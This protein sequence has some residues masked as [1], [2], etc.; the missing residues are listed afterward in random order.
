VLTQIK[1]STAPHGRFYDIKRYKLY[2]SE[3]FNERFRRYVEE[4]GDGGQ[5]YAEEM[6]DDLMK[7]LGLK[8]LSGDD[9]YACATSQI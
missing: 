6:F 8:E 5:A 4:V 3:K 9:F 1:V 7:T 2:A